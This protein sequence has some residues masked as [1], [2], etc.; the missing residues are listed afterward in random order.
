MR[1]LIVAG[2]YPWPENAGSRLRLA[3]AVGGLARLGPTDLVSVVRETRTDFDPPPDIPGLER[4]GRVGFDNRTD[5]GLAVLGTLTRPSKPLGLQ[6]RQ[7]ALIR[8]GVIDFMRGRYDLVWYFGIRAW[9][10][11]GNLNEAPVILDLED[12]EDR[13]IKA[14]LALADRTGDG[15]MRRAQGGLGQILSREDARRWHRLQLAAAR[16]AS[17]TVV[18]SN[19]DA[20]RAREDGLPRVE[21]IPN[22]YPK[23]TVPVGRTSVNDPPVVMFPGLL[24]Y[25]PNVQA[26][27]FL[28]TEIGPEL[29]RHIPEVRIRLVGSA[30]PELHRLDDPP[31]VVVTGQVP[32]MD[33]ELAGSD[34]VI[35]PLRYGSGTRLKIVEAF[36]QKVPV[37]STTVGAEG[38]GVSNGE[39]LL[40]ADD[41]AGL[42]AACLRLLTDVGL[43]SRLVDSAYE[44]FLEEFQ[45]ER[46]ET[47]IGD[48]GLRVTGLGNKG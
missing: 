41:S 26:A 35:V 14:R 32:S 45:R 23:V 11:V 46:I 37:V 1:T 21:V 2:D 16:R 34:L 27:E 6:W 43:R 17:V 12:L 22:A 38:L 40:V 36:A 5:S 44:L 7:A 30:A 31:S 13:K 25:P 42:A 33:E 47:S 29:R 20:Q 18:C 4:F 9:A 3:T 19:L 28:A 39:H 10:Q 15:L 48:L 24:T 8:Q